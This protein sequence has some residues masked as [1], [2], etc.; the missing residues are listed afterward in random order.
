MPVRNNTLPHA[1]YNTMACCGGGGARSYG[2]ITLMIAALLPNRLSCTQIPASPASPPPLQ[3]LPPPPP[4]PPSPHPSC[5]AVNRT[6]SPHFLRRQSGTNGSSCHGWTSVG[7]STNMSLSKFQCST[8]VPDVPEAFR[9]A[10][11]KP[12]GALYLYCNVVA[13]GTVGAK[14]QQLFGQLVPQLMVGNVEICGSKNGSAVA[15]GSHVVSSSWLAQ[16]QYFY[17]DSTSGGYKCVGGAVVN[18]SRGYQVE[19]TM[20][21]SSNSI[22]GAWTVTLNATAPEATAWERGGGVSTIAVS[23]PQQ[24]PKLSWSRFGPGSLRPYAAFEAWGAPGG[25][26]ASYP[27]GV[28]DVSLNTSSAVLPRFASW[29]STTGM[30]ANVTS[31]TSARWKYSRPRHAARIARP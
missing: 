16:A 3:L 2:A 13:D 19:L 30:V 26:T 18:V 28:W 1:P 12:G 6:T 24:N 20:E 21:Q 23:H 17:Q 29:G 10:G 25:D 11:S 7:S 4:P 31:P 9:T 8:T 5:R 14:E 27:A 15:P 22:G